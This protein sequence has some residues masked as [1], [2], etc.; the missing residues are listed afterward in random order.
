MLTIN[1]NQ[2]PNSFSF[3]KDDSLLSQIDESSYYIYSDDA[4]SPND[5]MDVDNYK[6]LGSE[7]FNIIKDDILNPYSDE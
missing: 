6:S 2:T 4:I 1:N 3:K 5:I 7:G